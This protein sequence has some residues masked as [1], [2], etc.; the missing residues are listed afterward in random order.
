MTDVLDAGQPSQL[1]N[2]DI[3]LNQTTGIE[4]GSTIKPENTIHITDD[5]SAAT[6]SSANVYQYMIQVPVDGPG[7][8]VLPGLPMPKAP[9]VAHH[10]EPPLD[11]SLQQ[12]TFID[13]TQTVIS[14]RQPAPNNV[15]GGQVKLANTITT[16][17][18]EQQQSLNESNSLLPGMYDCILQHTSTML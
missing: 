12:K 16:Q 10:T 3:P 18:M 13:T 7:T 9:P 4:T 11:Q 17:P 8:V 5:S 15:Q 1:S 2:Q 14:Q 6:K